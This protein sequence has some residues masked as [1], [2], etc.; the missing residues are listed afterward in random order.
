MR[1]SIQ[2]FCGLFC[3][4]V[5]G[6]P[7]QVVCYKAGVGERRFEEGDFEE[8]AHGLAFTLNNVLNNILGAEVLR[9]NNF[10]TLFTNVF[11]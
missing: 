7:L 8:H 2:S 9:I 4:L 6:E 1:G 10:A 11:V 3:A 5:G